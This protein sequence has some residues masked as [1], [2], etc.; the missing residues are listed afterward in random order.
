[1]PPKRLGCAALLV[2]LLAGVVFV[3]MA[4][5]KL[6]DVPPDVLPKPLI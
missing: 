3:L 1:M 2:E 6:P 4:P 5:N